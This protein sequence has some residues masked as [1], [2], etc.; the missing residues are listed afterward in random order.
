MDAT[1]GHSLPSL[2]PRK[3]KPDADE[4]TD[5]PPESLSDSILA[6]SPL[7]CVSSN[8]PRRPSSAS[9]LSQPT[10][11]DPWRANPTSSGSLSTIAVAHDIPPAKRPRI[12]N[13]PSS[14]RS[15]FTRPQ[16]RPQI[17]LPSPMLRSGG[18]LRDDII[19]MGVVPNGPTDVSKRRTHMRKISHARIRSRKPSVSS[20]FPIDPSSP[21][22]PCLQPLINRQTLKELD[23]D[24]ILRNPQL[25]KFIHSK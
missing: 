4:T 17:T 14:P 13:T 2:N 20:T 19:D 18:G 22:I 25:R 7:P 8:A 5:T 16:R 3:R 15:A 9:W 24:A 10:N 1:H 6:D 23:L 11:R 21:H 12:E